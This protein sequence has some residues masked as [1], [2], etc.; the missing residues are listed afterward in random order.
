MAP[1]Q[2]FPYHL[3]STHGGAAS[4]LRPCPSRLDMIF[5]RSEQ[6]PGARFLLM[7]ASGVVVVWGLQF[8]EPI[9]LPFAV[10]L[11]LATLSLPMVLGLVRRGMPGPVAIFIAVG[12]VV[13]VFGL[14]IVLAY[15]SLPDLETRLPRYQTALEALWGRFLLWASEVSNRPIDALVGPDLLGSLDV[16]DLAQNAVARTTKLVSRTFLV[17]LVMVFVLAEATVFP[18]KLR[19]LGDGSA[20]GE[21]RM[22]KVIAEIQSYLGIKTVISL[23]T[24]LL[25]GGFCWLM[26]LDFPILLGLVAFALN[27]VPTV[28]SILAAIPAVLLS[29]I[30]N[31]GAFAP[32]L[33]V[34]AGYV[35]V[36]TIFGNIIEPN[37]MGRRL[38]LSPLVVV[39]SLL[40]WNF[41]WGP[42]G[43][44]LSVPLTMVVKI[45]LEN[46]QDLRWVAVLLDK[47]SPVATAPK[48]SGPA[49][50][51]RDEG[52]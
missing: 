22:A 37:L 27:Y 43:A 42:V 26:G 48:E 47:Q 14:L 19:A 38:G 13:G 29:L 3:C 40:F 50:V 51:D 49:N 52:I 39:L 6:H 34:A 15:Q 46:T 5:D 41:V 23:L 10:A 44:L 28:G 45:W 18:A 16:F 11:C 1:A 24:G 31:E 36:N 33:G 35:V 20:R 8:A 21:E 9:L 4:F 32:A 2:E 12:V 17:L 25:L 30:L 7:L